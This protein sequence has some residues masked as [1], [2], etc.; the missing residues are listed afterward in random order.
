[1][2]HWAWS[3]GIILA[4]VGLLNPLLAAFIH[5]TSELTFI[6]NSTRLLARREPRESEKI[7][8]Q[9]A[10]FVREGAV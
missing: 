3:V 9:G 6:L 8:A 2:A 4:S 5:V 1:M 10:R 7:G